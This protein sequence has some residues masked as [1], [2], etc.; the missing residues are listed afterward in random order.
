MKKLVLGAAL[1]GWGLGVLPAA[2][3]NYEIPQS[4]WEHPRSGMA[5][6]SQKPLRECMQAW[7]AVPG[8]R[9][10]IHHGIGDEEQLRAA[11]L[12]YWLVSLAVEGDRIELMDDLRQNE[13]INVE[14]R[15][16]Q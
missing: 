2:A 14:I 7:M 4:L 1:A 12:R 16:L 5:I 13:S 6:L 8:A 15:E 10:V 11:E 3:Q 9:L